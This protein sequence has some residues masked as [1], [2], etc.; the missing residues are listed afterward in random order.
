MREFAKW[1]PGLKVINLNPVAEVRAEI[2]AE[3][4]K[5]GMNV[6]VTTYDALHR[7][8]ELRRRFKWHLIVFDEAHKLKNTEG[9]TIQ[10]SRALPSKRR[11]LM[12]GTPLQNN[13]TELWSLLNFMMPQLF[14]SAAD[15]DAWFNFDAATLAG[16]KRPEM[17]QAQKMLVVQILHRVMKPFMLRRT[18]ADLATKLPS[19]TEINISVQLSPLQL[20]LYQQLLQAKSLFETTG[21]AGSYHNILMQLRKACNHPY[22]FDDVEEEDQDEFGEHLILNSGKLVFLDKLLQKVV[23]QKEQALIFSQFTSML[24]ILEDFCTM[25]GIE[26]CRLDGGTDLLER[27]EAIEDFTRAGTSKVVFL[28]STRAGGLG[29]NLASANHVVLY[30]SDWN[31][32]CDLQAMD[33]AHRIGQKKEVFVYRLVTKGTLEEKIVERQAIKLKAD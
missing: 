23:A 7:C 22:L 21:R 6:C 13:L 20:K 32:Q 29:L 11:L 28:V 9:T 18:K 4:A 14:S 12:T 31:P 26:Y 24:N 8:P 16:A 3:M 30:D 25:R 1:A 5:P 33:R 19:K 27:E 15:F 10:L 2:L 17:N